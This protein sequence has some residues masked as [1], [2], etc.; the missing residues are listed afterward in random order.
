MFYFSVNVRVV[1]N[2]NYPIF[3]KLPP[4]DWKTDANST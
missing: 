3:T 1:K 4:K 2:K